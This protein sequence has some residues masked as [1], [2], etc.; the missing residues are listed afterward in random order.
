MTTY[1]IVRKLI[2]LDPTGDHSVYLIIVDDEGR[3][4]PYE[5]DRLE[6]SD[7]DHTYEIGIR[8]N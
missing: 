3:E 8:G 7:A 1:D 4:R 5:I 6:I 2:A